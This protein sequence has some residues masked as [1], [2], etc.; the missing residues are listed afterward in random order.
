MNGAS[1]NIN[2]AVS[3]LVAGV[4]GWFRKIT[5]GWRDLSATSLDVVETAESVAYFEQILT[6]GWFGWD[7]CLSGA[8]EAAQRVTRLHSCQTRP[9]KIEPRYR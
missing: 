9:S 8:L 5:V 1:F 3:S 7:G 4:S 6:I 2:K